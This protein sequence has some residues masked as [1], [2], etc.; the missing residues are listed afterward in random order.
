MKNAKRQKF[1]CDILGHFQTLCDLNGLPHKIIKNAK[2]W[3][4]GEF[5]KNWRFR[6][7]NVTRQ[8]NFDRT[9]IDGKCHN[10]I[11]KMRLFCWFSN[12]VEVLENHW[13]TICPTFWFSRFPNVKADFMKEVFCTIALL[14]NLWRKPGNLNREGI[15]ISSFILLWKGLL[16]HYCKLH[17]S[18]CCVVL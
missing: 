17:N 12:T 11:F 2:N 4:F 7:N 1:K 13:K 15:T 6:S 9:K 8:V 3:Q 18:F 14:G 10:W 5:L 16:L